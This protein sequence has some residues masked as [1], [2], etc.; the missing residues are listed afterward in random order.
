MQLREPVYTR[1]YD[2]VT[3]TKTW[4][5]EGWEWQANIPERGKKKGMFL[6]NT[7]SSILLKGWK[8]KRCRVKMVSKVFRKKNVKRMRFI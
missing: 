4:L 2:I 6:T 3:I 8:F 1:E 5:E 7:K